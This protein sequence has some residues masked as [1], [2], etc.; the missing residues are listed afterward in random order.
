MQWVLYDCLITVTVVLG[1]ISLD[2]FMSPQFKT[3][4]ANVLF[5]LSEWEKDK[6]TRPCIYLSCHAHFNTLFAHILHLKQGRWEQIKEWGGQNWLW[7]VSSGNYST[8]DIYGGLGKNSHFRSS[9]SV[10]FRHFFTVIEVE[11]PTVF[12][13][14]VVDCSIR[15]AD[16]SIRVSRSFL[17][18]IV[19]QKV[20]G[21]GPPYLHRLWLEVSYLYLSSTSIV[22]QAL[23]VVASRYTAQRS[24]NQKK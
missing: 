21:H 18:S 14:I 4:M 15:V 1:W 6:M 12:K 13:E 22:V 9:E 3:G 23:D 5:H 7:K 16:C 2:K 10:F 19:Q 20:G 24:V 8:N 17:A 11:L